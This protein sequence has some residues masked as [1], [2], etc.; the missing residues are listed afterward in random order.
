MENW[1]TELMLLFF[2]VGY[3]VYIETSYVS[4]ND[5]A[6]LESAVVPA[7]IRKPSGM[8]CLQ[9]WYHMHGQHVDT[10]NVFVKPGNQ[11]PSSPTWTKSGTQGTQW[12]L[13][14]VAVSSRAPFQVKNICLA[15]YCWWKSR[16]PNLVIDVFFNQQQTSREFFCPCFSCRRRCHRIMRCYS[17]IF[18]ATPLITSPL[19]SCTD[20]CQLLHTFQMPETLQDNLQPCYPGILFVS[21]A[22]L[23]SSK[24]AWCLYSVLCETQNCCHTKFNWNNFVK[25]LISLT[26]TRKCMF[27]KRF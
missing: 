26:R 5:T 25:L 13:G 22:E 17:D 7:T 19:E 2:S 11:L 18:L 12:R 8:I 20:R 4:A 6:I 14:Q 3:Y 24:V 23:A 16:N 21:Y 9:F 27:L 1:P 15:W 10:L